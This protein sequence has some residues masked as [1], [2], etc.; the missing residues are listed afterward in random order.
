MNPDSILIAIF[1]VCSADAINPDSIQI[2]VL[3]RTHLNMHM[4]TL[5]MLKWHKE[6]PLP[7][8]CAT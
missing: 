3:V 4:L 7:E 1:G 8:P 6:I 5:C 2:E